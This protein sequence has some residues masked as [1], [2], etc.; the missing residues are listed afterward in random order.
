MSTVTA[1]P[2]ARK[3]Q[4]GLAVITLAALAV[5]GVLAAYAQVHPG[6]GK[7][8]F[9][10]GFSA[11]KPMKS[12]LGT[13]ATA[14]VLVQ[15]LSALAMWGKLPGV[16]N[17]PSW[18]SGLHRWSGTVAFVLT[19]PVA[20]HCVWSLGF[21]T[22]DAR[23]LTHSVLGCVFYGVFTAKMLSL[24]MHKLPGWTLP[25]LGG[26]LAAVLTGLWFSASFWY[27]TQ[28]ALPLY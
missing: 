22:F 13:G 4:W 6:N 27:F 3:P 15:V 28:D 20:F 9:T 10:L 24:R 26:L 18:V 8:L 5:A 14:L 7:T 25:I 12:W 17:A 2:V 11:M 21:S 19:L 1:P 16:S 23:T